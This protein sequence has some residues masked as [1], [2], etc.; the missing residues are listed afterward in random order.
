MDS[1]EKDSILTENVKDYYGEVLAGSD[2][3]Q[4][5]ACC[6]TDVL[7]AFAREIINDI[8]PEVLEKFYGCGSPI[9]ELITGRTVVDLGCGTGRDCYLFSRLVG[10]QG[11]VIG[12]DMTEQQLAVAKTH[13]AYHRDLWGY[14]E[15]NVEFIE[16]YIEDLS[17]IGD[18]SAD[19]VTSNCVLNLSP[20]KEKVFSEI[21]RILKPGGELFFSDIFALQRIPS[22]LMA[23][24]VLHGE[25]LAG[26][27]YTEDFRRLL[28]K[29]GINDYRV[30]SQ[31]SVTI[32]N[33]EMQA[34]IG[35]VDFVSMT[36]R[37]F[38]IDVEDR[39]EDFGQVAVYQGGIEQSPHAYRL[40][41]HHLFRVGKA[42]PICS[43]TARM[44]A[45]T[46]LGGHFRIIGD[47]TVHHGLFDCGP[48]PVASSD[49]QGA[50]GACC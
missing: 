13:Q 21:F 29:L 33:P 5:S 12:I 40:D 43:N 35:M 22:A 1:D 46:R 26:A 9:P 11:R 24:P 30:M 44:L 50:G 34:K 32:D 4:T 39:C 49:N 18:D 31:S 41:D 17:L 28:L 14:E 2:D 25:C 36:I 10:P 20:D 19:V 38:K 6:P 45:L 47:E 48:S 3:L 23:D 15:S 37:A 8:H 27:I 42:E 16:G 7:T